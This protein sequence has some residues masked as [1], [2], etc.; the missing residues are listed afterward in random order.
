M[1]MSVSSGMQDH[2]DLAAKTGDGGDSK[3][4]V[5]IL[6]SVLG[7]TSSEASPVGGFLLFRS[8]LSFSLT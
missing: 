2:I 7:W 1:R 4:S 6:L 5:L 8:S 3:L